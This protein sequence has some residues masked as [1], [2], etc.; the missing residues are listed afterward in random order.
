MANSLDKIVEL[1]KKTGDNCIIL[2]A[3]GNPSY[4]VMD[5]EK[6]QKLLLSGPAKS[7]VI[8]LTENELL[9]KINNDIA[10]WKTSVGQDNL[11]FEDLVKI[12]EKPEKSSDG[13]TVDKIASKNDPF[14]SEKSLNE[15]KKEE[16]V[17]TEEKYYFEPID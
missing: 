11:D 3:L 13:V 10:T 16:K 5:L 12:M 7:S 2:D 14:Y 4:V 1:I 17:V 8:G 15:A 9:N 6:Y